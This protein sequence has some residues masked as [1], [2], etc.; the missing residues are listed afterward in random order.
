[1]LQ[2]QDVSP[3]SE[4]FHPGSRVKKI[5]DPHQR[6]QVFLTLKT[7][8]RLPEKLF[9]MFILDPDFFPSR[10]TDLGVKKASDPGSGSAV[11]QTGMNWSGTH[12]S[13]LPLKPSTNYSALKARCEEPGCVGV[14]FYDLAFIAKLYNVFI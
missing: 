1:M 11:L 5:P 7:I 6:I 3:G 10:I 2:I 9:G 14:C 13:L 12:R 4:F 8:Y